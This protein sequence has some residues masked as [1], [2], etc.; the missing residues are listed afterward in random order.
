MNVSSTSAGPKGSFSLLSVGLL[1][2]PCTLRYKGPGRDD[3]RFAGQ[4]ALT[5]RGSV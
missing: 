3:I 2:A 5:Q 4:S 1:T